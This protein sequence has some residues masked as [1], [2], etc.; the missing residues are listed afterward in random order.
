MKTSR[1]SLVNPCVWS[2][3][4][5]V[6]CAFLTPGPYNLLDSV[7]SP[8]WCAPSP[9][10]WICLY[11]VS[12]NGGEQALYHRELCIWELKQRL[13]S[14]LLLHSHRSRRCQG[15]NVT[16]RL[17]LHTNTNQSFLLETKLILCVIGFILL[18]YSYL[19]HNVQTKCS[20]AFFWMVPLWNP[21]DA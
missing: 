5:S 10:L 19:F 21:K 18:Y 16:R 3:G 13:V 1:G 12:G 7:A 4:F 14:L 17:S 9:C 2:T 15:P 6:S 20:F 11:D 8:H